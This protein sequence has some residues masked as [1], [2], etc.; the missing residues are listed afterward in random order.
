MSR[1]LLVMLVL[2]SVG[3]ASAWPLAAF[4][5]KGAEFTSAAA[6]DVEVLLAYIDPGVAGF[7][8][9][10]V[11]GFISS[12]GYMARSYVGRAKRLLFGGGEAGADG[13]AE[14]GELLSVDGDVVIRRYGQGLGTSDFSQH[15]FAKRVGYIGRPAGRR[16]QFQKQLEHERRHTGSSKPRG[17]RP[18]IEVRIDWLWVAHVDEIP[19]DN[20]SYLEACGR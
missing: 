4:A 19:K 14:G 1:P 6:G 8:I 20:N 3:A 18:P 2:A 10:A 11:L 12:I 15:L 13:D 7:V 5:Y 16:G 9:V 17:C